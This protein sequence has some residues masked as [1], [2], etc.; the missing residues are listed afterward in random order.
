MLWIYAEKSWRSIN[1][2]Y[3]GLQQATTFKFMSWDFP[4]RERESG[5]HVWEVIRA[6]LHADVNQSHW[7]EKNTYLTGVVAPLPLRDAEDCCWLT[8]L[9]EEETSVIISLDARA[10]GVAWTTSHAST[11]FLVALRIKYSW[12]NSWCS[13]SHASIRVCSKS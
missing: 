5:E 9:G 6:N 3:N 10:A 12:A 11:T 8:W 4:T 13:S 1:C 7:F 2:I